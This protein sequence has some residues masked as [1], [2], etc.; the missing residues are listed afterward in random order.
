[1]G[2]GSRDWNRQPFDHGPDLLYQPASRLNSAVRSGSNGLLLIANAGASGP[3]VKSSC[4]NGRLRVC[5]IEDESQ[6]VKVMHC[7]R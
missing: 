5:V 2:G 3:S 4:G 6:A 1:M 7:R